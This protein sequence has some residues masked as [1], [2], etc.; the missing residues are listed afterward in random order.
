MRP[1]AYRNFVDAEKK[2]DIYQSYL[3]MIED[4]ASSIIVT[5]KD[6]DFCLLNKLIKLNK[7]RNEYVSKTK[8]KLVENNGKPIQVCK[9][10]SVTINWT[11]PLYNVLHVRFLWL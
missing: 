8:K 5:I 4:E 2:I 6:V 9:C 7:T 11:L 3:I 1:V 10:N